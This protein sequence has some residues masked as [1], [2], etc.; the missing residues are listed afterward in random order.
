MPTVA[1][2][3]VE[4]LRKADV[5]RLFGVPGGGSNLEVLEAA[6]EQGL[7]FVLCRQESAA[8]IM[9]AVTG[10]LTGR[11]GAALSTLGPGV[12]ASATGLAHAF[13]DRSPV[14]FLSDRHSEATL[15]FATHQVLDHAAHLA[16]IVKASLTLT[17]DSASHLMAHAAQ[18]ALKEPRGP[19][20]LDLPADL[21]GRAALP[22]AV[23]PFPPATRP[24][25]AGLLD[26]AAAMIR[27]ARRPLV[28]AGLQCRAADAKW[29]RAFCEALPAPLLTTYKA[30]GAMPDPHPLAMGVFTGGALEE[31]VVRR[32][33]LVIAFGLDTVELIPRPWP[34]SSPLVSLARSA[35]SERA[36]AYFSP[37]LEVV[38][39]LALILEELAPRL[40][41]ADARAD[42][43]VAEVDRLRRE[44]LGALEVAVPGLAPHRVVQLTRE[45]TP[46]GTIASVDAGAHMF[47]ATAYWHAVEPGECLISNGL[48]T[49]GFALPAAIAAQLVYPERRVVCFT[50]AGG[51]LQVVAELETA[52]R[53]RLPITIVVFND[54]A[55]SLIQIKQEQKGYQGVPMRYEGPD[56]AA[57][58]QAEGLGVFTA[59]D[60]AGVRRALFSA[61]A[62]DGPTLI[63]AR[64]DASGYR[65]TLE[66]IRG[67][68]PSPITVGNGAG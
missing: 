56:L 60:E 42:W 4:G 50:G 49:M 45:L 27:G 32:A 25:D 47:P 62:Q 5:A 61:L 36:G 65:R 53:L 67:P 64:I 59:S 31:P 34:Y 23:N 63:D 51:L 55:L 40:T 68:N 7:P 21:A 2:L 48:A 44:R 43:D 14:I 39:D 12:T 35:S 1:Q 24:P 11:P 15:A 19:V 6:R 26:Q 13:L 58:A 16:P 37:A 10:E 33:D 46:A 54:G 30:K 29:L 57:L 9:A 3:V 52:A 38:G 18:L 28:V 17:A 8:L 20:H 66:I 41:R 22:L